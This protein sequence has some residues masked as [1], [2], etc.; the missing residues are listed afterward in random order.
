MTPRAKRNQ[1][2]KEFVSDVLIAQVVNVNGTPFAT[3]PALVI[4]PLEYL[5]CRLPPLG[6]SHV[7]IVAGPPLGRF[8]VALLMPLVLAVRRLIPPVLLDALV[9][10]IL[11]GLVPFIQLP[12]PDGFGRDVALVRPTRQ[13]LTDGDFPIFL[14]S[15]PDFGVGAI[16]FRPAVF[17][18]NFHGAF[19]GVQRF[20]FRIPIPIP[21]I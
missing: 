6:R 7:L 2:K 10:R 8:P 3:A 4:V 13:A 17:P 1:F 5:V 16:A 12:H 11:E 19:P 18:V 21:S 15:L 9:P 14:D 20:N